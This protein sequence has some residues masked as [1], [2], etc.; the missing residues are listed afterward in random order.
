MVEGT[1]LSKRSRPAHLV[2]GSDFIMEIPF[3]WPPGTEIPPPSA[4][5]RFAGFV[6]LYFVM[7]SL[8]GFVLPR[9]WFCWCIRTLFPFIPEHIGEHIDD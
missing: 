2:R 9:R 7:L 1:S 4:L 5:E 8:I 6:V 3:G